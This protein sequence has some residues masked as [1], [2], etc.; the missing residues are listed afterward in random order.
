MVTSILYIKG[1]NNIGVFNLEREENKVNWR[2]KRG[3]IRRYYRLKENGICVICGVAKTEGKTT[4]EK[5]LKKR[6][7]R[8]L[9]FKKKKWKKVNQ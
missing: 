1:V 5:C 6:N 4:C 7:K 9:E 8:Q 2:D 3:P